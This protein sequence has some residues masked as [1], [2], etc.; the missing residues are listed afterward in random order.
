MKVGG[1]ALLAVA[2]VAGKFIGVT[3]FSWVAV[4]LGIAQLPAGVRWGHIYGVGAVA[5]IGFTVSLFI[6]GLAFDSELL[7]DDAKLGTLIA[8]VI[9]AIAGA[10]VLTIAGRRTRESAV[11]AG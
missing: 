4:K 2:L 1:P 9:A 5:G 11:E 8:S 3:L 6:A 7:Q 10:V